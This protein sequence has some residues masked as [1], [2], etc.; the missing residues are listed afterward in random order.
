MKRLKQRVRDLETDTQTNHFRVEG[1]IGD[2]DR[3]VRRHYNES[4]E[5]IKGLIE[6]INEISEAVDLLLDHHGLELVEK[7]QV[8][9]RLALRATERKLLQGEKDDNIRRPRRKRQ[10][11]SRK[12]ARSSLR[13]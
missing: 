5:V 10:K 7:K 8:D 1:N 9:A 4:T 13:D 3:E 11:L 12:V 2:L 6:T